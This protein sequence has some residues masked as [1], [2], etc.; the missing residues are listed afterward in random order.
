MP[1]G[2]G[3]LRVPR[4][5]RASHARSQRAAQPTSSCTESRVCPGMTS[6]APSVGVLLITVLQLGRVLAQQNVV[7]GTCTYESQTYANKDVWK[8]EPCQ[9]CVC[10]DGAV[11]CDEVICD[12]EPLDCPS[13]EIPEGECCPI[14]PTGSPPTKNPENNGGPTPPV[15]AFVSVC[16]SA[17]L[18]V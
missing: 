1:D 9:I 7:L 11:L 12:D 17:C 13:P 2:L 4:G 16:P 10:D 18:S 15:S 14:C 3:Y 6:C 5:E 8:P